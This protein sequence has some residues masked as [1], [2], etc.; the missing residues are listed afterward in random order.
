MLDGQYL[1][2]PFVDVKITQMRPFYI[3]GEVN[4]PGE[5]AYRP[6]IS[7]T[8]AASIAGGFTYRANEDS[9]VVSREE[10]GRRVKGRINAEDPIR[11]G[12][13]ITVLERWF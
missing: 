10:N 4:N 2:D 5:Y 6:G 7:M 12:D 3:L 8:A 13:Q 9:F 1:V 11:P